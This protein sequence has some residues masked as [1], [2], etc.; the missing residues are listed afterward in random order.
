M[1][2]PGRHLIIT[3]LLAPCS[4]GTR[5]GCGCSGICCDLPPLSHRPFPP[6]PGS[7]TPNSTMVF[8][9]LLNN[10]APAVH[11]DNI[12]AFADI[13]LFV[14]R[15]YFR[16]GHSSCPIHTSPY[17]AGTIVM[18]RFLDNPV[19][20]TDVGKLGVRLLVSIISLPGYS[21]SPAGACE[22]FQIIPRFYLCKCLRST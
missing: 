18:I 11:G 3:G 5:L 17:P 21:I 16:E 19:I 7:W 20:Q 2:M 22:T 10:A 12:M 9:A 13:F 6:L 15:T 8:I 1:Y 4:S 14:G